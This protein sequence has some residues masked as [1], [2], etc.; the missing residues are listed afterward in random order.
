MQHNPCFHSMA[1]PITE[2]QGGDYFAAQMRH[3]TGVTPVNPS[4]AYAA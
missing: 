1:I 3:S 4:D 2:N